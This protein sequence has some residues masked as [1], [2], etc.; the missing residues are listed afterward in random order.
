L[1]DDPNR[2]DVVARRVLHYLLE[3]PAAA[4]TVAGV[5]LWW[6]G[7][8]EARESLVGDVLEALVRR[9]WLVRHGAEPETRIYG[10]NEW[11]RAAADHFVTHSGEQLDG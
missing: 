10:F 11:N 8:C 2:R 7:E 5:R 6:L 9:G 4:D 3:H 1:T